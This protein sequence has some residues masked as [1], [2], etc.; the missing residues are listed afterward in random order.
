MRL[1][2]YGGMFNFYITKFHI[3]TEQ[4]GTTGVFCERGILNKYH[5]HQPMAHLFIN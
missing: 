4:L 2:V 5:T 3:N 1:C